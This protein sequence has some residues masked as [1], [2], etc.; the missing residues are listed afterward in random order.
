MEMIC[1]NREDSPHIV[2]TS[3][4]KGSAKDLSFCE[5]L[6]ATSDWSPLSCPVGSARSCP[7]LLGL[8]VL[9]GKSCLLPA[10]RGL[11]CLASLRCE[12]PA[13]DCDT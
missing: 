3:I 13:I 12:G 11:P 8:V 2:R 5:I 6:I 10:V 9:S 7:G 4:R 1:E